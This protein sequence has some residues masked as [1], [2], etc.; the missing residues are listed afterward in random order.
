[1]IVTQRAIL[2]FAF[3]LVFGLARVPLERSLE[4][5]LRASGFRAG[6][7]LPDEATRE[8]LGQAGVLAMLGGFRSFLATAFE[9]RAVTSWY[10]ADYKSVEVFYNL[11]T[12]LQP[13]EAGY[14]E[15]A[16]WMMESNA[17]FHY[18]TPVAGETRLERRRRLEQIPV[19]RERG[20]KFFADGLQFNPDD[21]ALNRAFAIYH[22]R[23]EQNYC[24]SA[25]YHL[26]AASIESRF[27]ETRQAAYTMALCSG[28][29][30][31]AYQLLRDIYQKTLATFG[32]LP[33]SY[34]INCRYLEEFLKVPQANRVPFRFDFKTFYQLKLKKYDP[35]T[36]T[37]KSQLLMKRLESLRDLSAS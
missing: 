12:Q 3:L 36:A 8:Q 35:K 29:E 31:E 33:E 23:R 11:T 13:R 27:S 18:E 25:N 26:R 7:A 19:A 20:K 4:S 28:K 37:P 1:M 17:A 9:L 30:V 10:D 15:M 16:A 2:V 24:E 21:F 34:V 14:W 22:D 6:M 5:D 32:F